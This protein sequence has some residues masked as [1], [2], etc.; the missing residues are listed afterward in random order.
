MTI[1]KC[2]FLKTDLRKSQN[3]KKVL[4]RDFSNSKGLMSEGTFYYKIESGQKF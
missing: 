4:L 1:T 2:H 3:R